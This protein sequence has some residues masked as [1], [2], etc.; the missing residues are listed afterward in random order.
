MADAPKNMK[1]LQWHNEKRKVKDLIP[2]SYNPRKMTEIE[3]R[4]LEDSIKEF[5]TVVPVV[6]NVGKRENVLVG[7]HQRA[8]IYADLG[9]DEI[10]VMVPSRELNKI[11]EKKLNLRLNKNTGSWDQEKLKE[12]DLT[13][14]LEVGFGD[15]DLQMFFDDVDVLE[16]SFNVQKAIKEMKVPTVKPGEIWQLGDHRL[17]CGDSTDPEQVK[18]LMATKNGDLDLADIIY[19]DPPYNI[20]LDYNN[21]A[22]MGGKA[23]NGGPNYG[24]TYDKKKDS[25]PIKEYST[26]ID[27][28]IKNAIASAKPNVHVFYWCDERNIGLIQNLFKENKIE[29]K[30]VCLWIKNNL[31]PTPQVA[32]IKCYE[33]CVY[34]TIGKPHL[35]K[36]IKNLTEVLNKEIESGNQMHEEIMDM[37]TLW[38]QKRDNTL[39]YEHPTQKPVTLAERPLKRCASPG[40]IILDLFGGS[41]S[42]LIACE[43]IKRK[44]RMIEQDPIFASVIVNRFEVFTNTKAKKL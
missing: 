34:G 37:M 23:T 12:M 21:N 42:T 18:K 11:E 25:K 26:F 10:D 43:Q 24:G 44:C 27:T 28:T 16:D 5:G 29:S 7:G 6:V 15:D 3:R 31:S 38:V 32:F 19:C 8:T 33:P 40:H 36:N 9:I 30:R 41:G 20:G 2:A 13:M 17:M 4:D 22:G 1:P 35:N 39:E 14:L